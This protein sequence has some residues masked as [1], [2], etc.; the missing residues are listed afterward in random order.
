MNLAALI[1]E[2]APPHMKEGLSAYLYHGRPPGGFLSAV[3]QNDLRRAAIQA[4]EHN[5]LA[6]AGYGQILNAMPEGSWGSGQAVK[7]WIKRGGLEGTPE[8]P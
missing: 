6:L 1:E 7:Q 4:D 8:E 3:L 2:K 5:R